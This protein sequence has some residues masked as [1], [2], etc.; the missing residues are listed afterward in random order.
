MSPTAGGG[1]GGGKARSKRGGQRGAQ[2]SSP[3]GGGQWRGDVKTTRRR[4]SGRPER[5]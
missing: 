5:R 3:R 2:R 4:Q 1:D